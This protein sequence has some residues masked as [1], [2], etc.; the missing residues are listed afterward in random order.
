VTGVD[1]ITRHDGGI[2]ICS[3]PD[4]IVSSEYVPSTLA[5]N[6]PVTWRDPVIGT[7]VQLAPNIDRSS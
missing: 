4:V 7:D 2:V 3:A 5:V 6:V 1:E